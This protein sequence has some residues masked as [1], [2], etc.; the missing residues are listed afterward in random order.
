MSSPSSSVCGLTSASPCEVTKADLCPICYLDFLTPQES[1]R[2]QEA[3]SNED[4]AVKTTCGHVFHA[5][6]LKTWTDGQ[7][8]HTCPMCRTE[9]YVG[10]W[11]MLRDVQ[12]TVA[13][14]QGRDR[15]ATDDDFFAAA[16]RTQIENS[17]VSTA[18]EILGKEDA[19]EEQIAAVAQSLA[20]N[21][22]GFW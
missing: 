3:S 10:P 4:R 19:D 13:R 14:W 5:S 20:G 15:P 9:Y 22:P 18:R 1:T 17:L 8:K 7:N 21:G 6:C 16:V 12:D 11:A 2:L